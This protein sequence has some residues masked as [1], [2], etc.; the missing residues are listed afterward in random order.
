MSLCD[1]GAQY[2]ALT[3]DSETEYISIEENLPEETLCH[4]H[5]TEPKYIDLLQERNMTSTRILHTQVPRQ[6][7]EETIHHPPAFQI[8]PVDI[9]VTPGQQANNQAVNLG[10]Q[11]V[12]GVQGMAGRRGQNLQ[13]VDPALVQIL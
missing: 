4:Y 7:I 5:D 3:E 2:S 12:P 13:W 9:V 1:E 6:A 10:I 11:R 8:L